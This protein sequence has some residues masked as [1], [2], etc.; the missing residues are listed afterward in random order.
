ML[1]SGPGDK[2]PLRANRTLQVI[3]VRDDD[4]DQAPVLVVQDVAERA[5]SAELSRFVGS[6]R[7]R[8]RLALDR[9]RPGLLVEARA[10]RGFG[11]LLQQTLFVNPSEDLRAARLHQVPTLELARGWAFALLTAASEQL[12]KASRA[13]FDVAAV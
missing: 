9:H 5:S 13:L 7:R 10:D 8:K 12:P 4:A 2:I 1:R 11:D 6:V 3:R